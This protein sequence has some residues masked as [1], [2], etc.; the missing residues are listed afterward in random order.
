MIGQMGGVRPFVTS[1][2][3]ARFPGPA[4]H[5]EKLITQ[6][7]SVT[8]ENLK[9]KQPVGRHLQKKRTICRERH[10]AENTS[11]STTVIFPTVSGRFQRD[12]QPRRV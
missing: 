8:V 5:P 4:I 6:H 2:T 7:T 10:C 12:A 9:M 3:T 11:V 1:D